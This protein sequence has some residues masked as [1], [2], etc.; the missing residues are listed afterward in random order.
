MR[1]LNVTRKEVDAS[2]L[3]AGTMSCTQIAQ[4]S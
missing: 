1:T 3:L 4:V 2:P